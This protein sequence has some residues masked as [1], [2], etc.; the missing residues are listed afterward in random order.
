[1]AREPTK[2]ALITVE[3]LSVSERVLLFCIASGT[4]WSKAGIT[5]KTVMAMVIKGMV[6]R[7]AGGHLTLTQ[8]GWDALAGLLQWPTFRA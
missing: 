5:E 8:Q 2:L 3:A 4:P 6:D 7:D 1:M